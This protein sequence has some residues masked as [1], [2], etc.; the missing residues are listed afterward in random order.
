MTKR[1]VPIFNNV[2]VRKIETESKT[3]GGVLLPE[4]AKE[5]PVKG[6]V[7][8]VGKGAICTETGNRIP[9]EVKVGDIAVF[10]QWAGHTVK[11]NGEELFIMKDQD[12]LGFEEDDGSA[13]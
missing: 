12:I 2:L 9:L 6:E 5:K 8:A 7:L 3:A 13:E 11:L 4:N 10:T 1:F